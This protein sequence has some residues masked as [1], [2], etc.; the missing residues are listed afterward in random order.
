MRRGNFLPIRN[1][2]VEDL[3]RRSSF[4]TICSVVFAE[5]K[6]LEIVEP[7]DDLNEG[8][9]AVPEIVVE[10]DPEAMG[11]TLPG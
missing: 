3:F 10:D 9:P 4:L 7:A 8:A 2:Q 1:V 5:V 11:I 6:L